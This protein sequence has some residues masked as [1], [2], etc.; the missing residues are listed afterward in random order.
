[1]LAK[2]AAKVDLVESKTYEYV[3]GY[4]FKDLLLVLTA[5][6]VS[7]SRRNIEMH[8]SSK[9]C[10]KETQSDVSLHKNFSENQGLTSD[11]TSLV[12]VD[13][14]LVELQ[15]KYQSLIDEELEPNVTAEKLAA[16]VL[17]RMQYEG[18]GL[19][20]LG[21]ID[22]EFGGAEVVHSMSPVD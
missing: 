6:A 20:E 18:R 16:Y 9:V 5:M 4:H 22:G 2:L 13:D 17:S 1:M 8:S 19:G 7:E 12:E 11:E 10:N 15:Q 14:D 3:G 21:S